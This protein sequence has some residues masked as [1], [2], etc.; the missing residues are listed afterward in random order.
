[1]RDSVM[2]VREAEGPVGLRCARRMYRGFFTAQRKIM[3]RDTLNLWIY[4]SPQPKK[5]ALL[6]VRPS[7]VNRVADEAGFSV[8]RK[9]TPNVVMDGTWDINAV[10]WDKAQRNEDFLILQG[11]Q[12]HVN[13][14][15]PWAR[16][17]LYARLE[18][19]IAEQGG[20]CDGC[21]TL[22]DIEARYRSLD[23][24]VEFA[25]RN[26]SPMSQ[27]EVSGHFRESGG[28]DISV[29][30]N[31]EIL[32]SG[33]GGH[34]LAIAKSLDLPAIPVCLNAVHPLALST[35]S[36]LSVVQSS[37]QLERFQETQ[38]Q[39]RSSLSSGIEAAYFAQR[40]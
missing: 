35:G 18:R 26:R 19:M 22:A 10:D 28:I 4:G 32:K 5:Y 29:A 37:V 27:A 13:G 38:V 34:R 30:R 21:R 24:V 7:D 15:V 14:G 39:S 12:Q 31:G 16:T 2:T 1:M 23:D 36:W 33:G 9:S 6:Y 11:V 3:L 25:R 40:K 20:L 8:F 17:G